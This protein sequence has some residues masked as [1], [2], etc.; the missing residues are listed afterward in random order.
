MTLVWLVTAWLIGII[1]ASHAAQPS[2]AWLVIAVTGLVGALIARRSANWR[3]MFLCVLAFGLGAA[4]QAS[5]QHPITADDLAF[6]NDRGSASLTGVIVDAPDVRDKSIHL[7]VQIESIQLGK[8]SRP[9]NGLALVE[10]DR[11]G[12]FA[13]GDQLTIRGQP[14]TP[15]T[16]DTFSYSDYLAQSG[17][18]TY[19][20]TPTITVTAHDQ[21]NPLLAALLT[22]KADAHDVIGRLLPSPQSALLTGILLGIRTDLPTDIRSAFDQTGTTRVLVID[23]SKMTIIAGLLFVLFGRLKDKRL[24]ALLIIIGLIAYTLFV[25]ATPPVVRAATMAG[26]AIIAARI[27]RQSDGL[28]SL[29][30]AVW[31]QTALDP[32]LIAD[33]GLLISAAST[34]GLILF[35]EPIT[36]TIE[37]WLEKRFAAATVKTILA[38]LADTVIVSL[39]VQIPSLPI[40]FLLFERFSAVGL[41]VNILISPAQPLILSL[42]LLSIGA[43]AILFPVGQ[44]FAWLTAIPL[45]YTLA[46]VRSAAQLPGASVVVSI[47]PFEVG[48]YYVILLGVVA[49]FRRPLEQRTAWLSRARQSLIPTLATPTV[50]ALGLG[51]AGLLWAFALARPDGRLHV[52]FL[53]D[54][55]GNAVLIQTPSGAHVLIDGGQNPTQLSAAVGD[56]LPFYQRDLDALII[57]QPKAS[58][59]TALPTLLTRYTPHSVLSSGQTATVPAYD[60]LSGALN[61]SGAPLINVAAGYKLQINDGV[62]IEVINPLQPPEDTA[63]PDDAALVLRLTY[64]NVSFLLTPDLSADAEQ[65]MITGGQYL[66]ANVLQ[67]PTH[68][69]DAANSDA[70]LKTVGAQVAVIEASAGSRTGQPAETVIKRLGSTPIYRTDQQGTLEFTSDGSALW[71]RTQ[72]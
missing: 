27:G 15:P 36:Q 48:I 61:A 71:V 7:R 45:T 8:T 44:V 63:K 60:V 25:G 65:A 12:T 69:D 66:G 28:S 57:T 33:A 54:V 24:S 11:L 20:L 22:L 64:R 5:S 30:F 14:L 23:G 4:R 59:I 55:G 13:Y 26:L 68:A 40:I 9:L 18:Y 51:I 6:Y 29:A 49:F 41:L 3:V 1:A 50:A 37:R 46:L 16:F 58:G 17:V 67:L 42:G 2:S 39:A 72:R 56:R 32:A 34:L 70:F 19:F 53:G 21:G 38:L 35:A 62:Q 43:G 10:A 52:W 31:L 47:T